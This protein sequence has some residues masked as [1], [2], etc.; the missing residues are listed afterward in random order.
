MRR[1]TVLRITQVGNEKVRSVLP[2]GQY[3]GAR[4][5]LYLIVVTSMIVIMLV[6]AA[7]INR[8]T[9]SSDDAHRCIDG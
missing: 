4:C 1:F 2:P 5:S 6:A 9:P 8:P 3:H 7:S